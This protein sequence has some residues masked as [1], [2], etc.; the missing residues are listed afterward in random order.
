MPWYLKMAFEI[1]CSLH[2]EGWTGHIGTGFQLALEL[3]LK[4][5]FVTSRYIDKCH[6][7]AITWLKAG[8]KPRANK[9]AEG[10]AG[11]TGLHG[12]QCADGR[13][14]QKILLLYWASKCRGANVFTVHASGLTSDLGFLCTQVYKPEYTHLCPHRT[15]RIYSTE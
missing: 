4:W 15:V 14:S 6:T 12:L 13:S 11:W 7:G 2:N 1:C 5:D 9:H 10:E 3:N 8:V